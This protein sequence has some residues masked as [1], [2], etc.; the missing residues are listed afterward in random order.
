MASDDA[1][2]GLA[3]HVQPPGPHF[4]EQA[5]RAIAP[6]P[7][8]LRLVAERAVPLAQITPSLDSPAIKAL[9]RDH[10]RV[11]MLIRA[12]RVRGHLIAKL[13]PL[14]LTGNDYHPE[15]DW[16][17][18]GFTE[19]DLDREFYLDYVLGLEKA[20]LRTIVEVLQP[21][22]PVAA[23]DEALDHVL[24]QL[25]SGAPAVVATDGGRAI[26]VL[27]RADVLAYL[28]AREG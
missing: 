23:T 13:D 8:E 11:I 16:R 17:T 24:G 9:V 19:A 27:T 4:F 14:G 10:L 26:G 6:R 28:A 22:L 7:R 25:A 12:Y 21:P 3:A 5:R 15:L 1:D 20:T 18:Y 2:H